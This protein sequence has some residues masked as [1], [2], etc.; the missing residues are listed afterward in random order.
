MEVT[1]E[2]MQDVNEKNI[3]EAG[4]RFLTGDCFKAL[5]WE[6]NPYFTAY[7]ETHPGR[8]SGKVILDHKPKMTYREEPLHTWEEDSRGYYYFGLDVELPYSNVVRALKEHIYAYS[9]GTS[10]GSLLEVLSEGSQACRFDR[11]DG[12]NT[13]IINDLWDYNS[14]L[15]GNYMKRIPLEKSFQ[16]KTTVLIGKSL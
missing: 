16:G 14:L 13:L 6:R 2:S 1:Y 9:L 5:S 12:K 10:G 4:I 7:P 15:W 8:A 3:Q 11:I